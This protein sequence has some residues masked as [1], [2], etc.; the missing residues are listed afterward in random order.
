MTLTSRQTAAACLVLLATAAP[1][2]RAICSIPDGTYPFRVIAGRAQVPINFILP[3]HP[4]NVANDHII[5]VVRED[6]TA[7]GIELRAS[8]DGDLPVMKLSEPLEPSTGYYLCA[9]Y[10]A[11]TLEDA[12]DC[13]F[14]LTDDGADDLD[15]P[16]APEVKSV[17]VFGYFEMDR[18]CGGDVNATIVGIT[19]DVPAE[20]VTTL[21]LRRS[22]DDDLDTLV[23]MNMVLPES[24][25]GSVSDFAEEGG[26]ATYAV[27]AIDLAGNQSADTTLEQYLGLPGACSCAS[28]PP[29]RPRSAIILLS[30]LLFGHL[31]NARR[32]P[33]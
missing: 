4:A 24:E 13:E 29:V 21:V 28:S 27:S 32:S 25:E 1:Q 2:A 5:F 9:G 31:K 23:R 18:E 33:F 7:T 30:L 16:S 11:T 15:S 26:T 14:I 12:G 3:A 17:E 20:D 19:T 10:A 8:M 6:M 22:L